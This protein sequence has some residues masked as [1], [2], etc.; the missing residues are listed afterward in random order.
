LPD[1]IKDLSTQYTTKTGKVFSDAQALLCASELDSFLL[2]DELALTTLT[3]LYDTHSHEDGWRKGLKSGREDLKNPCINMLGASNEVLFE[4]LVKYKDIEGG[5]LARTFIVHESK[6]R[7]NN[8]LMWAPKDLI[9]KADLAEPLR[10]L[11]TLAGVFEI[12]DPVK[13]L[14]D[15]WYN[16]IST[17][18]FEDRTGTVDR[19]GDSVLK[20]AM[21][22]QLSKSNDLVIDVDSMEE[23]IK[24]CEES[25]VGT[26]QVSFGHSRSDV[27]PI[28]AVIIKAL[29]EACDQELP[30]SKLLSKCNCEPIQFDRALDTLV[31]RE[32][33]EEPFR[34]RLPNGKLMGGLW[35]R[36]K[37][38]VYLQYLQI[39][40][41]P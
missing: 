8:S 12:P 21:L 23:A 40:A 1:I 4:D 38:E 35:Y 6:R 29:V 33:I 16:D 27:G 32:V 18:A 19:I 22:I 13:H 15:D 37:K 17:N 9:P 34:K 26:R 11:T 28:I 20:V 2:K 24:K 41:K 39:K 25:L 7:R 36:M 3:D 5:F 14:Y 10:R 31:Q 30:R